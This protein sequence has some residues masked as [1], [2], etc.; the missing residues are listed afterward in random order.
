MKRKRKENG[1][2]EK[3]TKEE[4]KKTENKRREKKTENKRKGHIFG[5]R[6][7]AKAQRLELKHSWDV[8]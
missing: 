4:K 5:M 3:K 2:E 1:I 6:V 7:F 8:R